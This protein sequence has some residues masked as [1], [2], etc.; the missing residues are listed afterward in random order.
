MENKNV[1][2]FWPHML[3]SDW[4]NDLSEIFG[5]RWIGEGPKTKEFEKKF[6]EKFGYN[7]CL[8]LNSGS[9]GLE[10]AYHLAGIGEGDEVIVEKNGEENIGLLKKITDEYV[11]IQVEDSICRILE[12]SK[13]TQKDKKTSILVERPTKLTYL[14]KGISWKPIYALDIKETA[15]LSCNANILSKQ[16]IEGNF[17]LVYGKDTNKEKRKTVYDIDN[18]TIQGEEIVPLFMEDNIEI[19][20]FY[21]HDANINTLEYG[22]FFVSSHFLPEGEIYVYK[23]TEFIGQFHFLESKEKTSI[24]LMLGES[25]LLTCVSSLEINELSEDEKDQEIENKETIRTVLNNQNDEDVDLTIRYYIGDRKIKYSEPQY[26]ARIN[27]CL[28]W[29]VVVYKQEEEG[30]SSFEAILYF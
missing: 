25:D 18:E 2:L 20:K 30:E 16:K 23:N 14:F 4:I 13:V 12:Y 6:G 29:D 27:N 8:S 11:D 7:Y 21:C 26:T 15:S 10:L 24:E 19:S 22:Y 5:T 3:K 28:E 9:A 17:K 1:P